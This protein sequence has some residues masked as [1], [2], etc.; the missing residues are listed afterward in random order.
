MTEQ[1]IVVSQS[2]SLNLE[3]EKALFDVVSKIRQSLNLDEIIRTT[4]EEIQLLLDVDR[5]GVVRL[6]PGDGWSNGVFI[7]E[8]VLPNVW[9]RTDRGRC[10]SRNQQSG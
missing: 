5:V 4:I 8:T 6:N 2:C 9:L 3:R 7:A 10:C 1:Q